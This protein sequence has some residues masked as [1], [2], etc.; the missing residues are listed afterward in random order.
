[1]VLSTT[2]DT[3]SIL[4]EI[5][6]KTLGVDQFRTDRVNKGFH[7]NPVL[8]F[9][10]PL[11]IVATINSASGDETCLIKGYSRFQ[12]DVNMAYRIIE[13]NL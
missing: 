10:F 7:L 4:D 1:M 5:S 9:T 3:L 2:F 13:L 8:Q 12:K 11:S 6:M